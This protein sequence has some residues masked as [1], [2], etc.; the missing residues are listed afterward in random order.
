MFLSRALTAAREIPARRALASARNLVDGGSLT[1][2][3]SALAYISA[4]CKLLEP[5]VRKIAT[6]ATKAPSGGNMQPWAFVVV[7][8]QDVLARG[9]AIFSSITSAVTR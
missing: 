4:L 8:D 3:A 2:V 1:I 5:G 9:H 7:R 6:A